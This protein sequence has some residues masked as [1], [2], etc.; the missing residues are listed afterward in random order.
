MNH[1][2][3]QRHLP[4]MVL[5]A[6]GILAFTSSAQAALVY[7][8]SNSGPE[9]PAVAPVRTSNLSTQGSRGVRSNRIHAQSFQLASP[10]DVSRIYLGYQWN[11]DTGTNT[12]IRIVEVDDVFA[13]SY[14]PG[15]VVASTV[16]VPPTA[17]P[18]AGPSP[19]IDAIELLWDPSLS[20]GMPLALSPR[21]GNE[22]Y[23]IEVIGG[24]D[25]GS[26]IALIHRQTVPPTLG[27]TYA[28]GRA[29]EM[30]NGSPVQMSEN[31]DFVLV[32][33]AVPEPSAIALAIGGCVGLVAYRWRRRAAV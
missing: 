3:F 9:W 25:S 33:T 28:F 11:S 10:I 4:S 5:V 29:W 22:G 23:A 20:G 24:A 21:T 31:H 12:S 8:D 19:I 32:I 26:P 6:A 16:L 13:T 1:A 17:Q 2:M 14:T 18:N 7:V 27:G 15:A 30:Q